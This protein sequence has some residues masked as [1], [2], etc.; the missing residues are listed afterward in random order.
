MAQQAQQV[1]DAMALH[2]DPVTAAE[3]AQKLAPL[4]VNQVSAQ[5]SRLEDFGVVE[6]TPWFGEKKT[7]FQLAERFFNIWYLMRASRRVRRRLAWLV[8]FLE[9]WFEREELAEQARGY[10]SRD[11][12]SVGLK[13]YAEM[14]LAYSQT[15]KDRHLRRSLESAGLLAALDVSVR[16]LID[17]SDLP[18]ELQDRRQRMQQLRELQ[19]RV[20][21]M[22]LDGVDP[23]ELWRVLGGSPHLSLEQKARVVN[24][25][26]TLG[27]AG[28]R[29]LYGKLKRAE[30]RLLQLC[31]PSAPD[32]VTFV[33]IAGRRRNQRY[34]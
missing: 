25:L 23:R 5:L 32:A 14:A 17:F 15:L 22:H 34:L 10:L 1:V 4:S 16:D 20:L 18:P 33:R 27:V 11:P 28:V 21:E 6:K 8:K 13:R 19:S 24:E 7:A 9:A 30:H 12:E 26:P 31:G 2:W 3:L 29:E